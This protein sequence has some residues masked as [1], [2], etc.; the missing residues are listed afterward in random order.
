M[1]GDIGHS[2]YGK[3]NIFAINNEGDIFYTNPKLAKVCG[4][5]LESHPDIVKEYQ[6]IS[7]FDSTHVVYQLRY[8]GDVAFLADIRKSQVK[9]KQL[10]VYRNIKGIGV[11]YIDLDSI[12]SNALKEGSWHIE[13]LDSFVTSHNYEPLKK[14]VMEMEGLDNES[15]ERKLRADDT[16]YIVMDYIRFSPLLKTD[17][18][19]VRKN[20]SA[21]YVAERNF[22]PPNKVM[23]FSRD[24]KKIKN[25]FSYLPVTSCYE[26][27][28]VF[29]MKPQ[30]TDSTFF[31]EFSYVR[32]EEYIRDKKNYKT[33]KGYVSLDLKNDSLSYGS[34]DSLT[35]FFIT[36][37][38]SNGDS[39]FIAPEFKE[40]EHK[41]SKRRECIGHIL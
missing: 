26:E 39:I 12:K 22:G 7:C 38:K 6:Y 2:Y 8:L 21:F 16:L 41:K 35:K 5:F 34:D 3:K 9:T 40:G 30:G 14:I 4:K 10:I 15:F 20:D 1:A 32:E 29:N 37:Y 24:G 27:P 11:T 36:Q 19:I 13:P 23:L 28:P 31:M 18:S 25:L 17:F 33:Y